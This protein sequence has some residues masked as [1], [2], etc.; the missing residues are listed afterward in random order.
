MQDDQNRL[1]YPSTPPPPR[2]HFALTP[3]R[4]LYRR[5]SSPSTIRRQS[6]ESNSTVGH[7][8]PPLV[9]LVRDMQEKGDPSLFMVSPRTTLGMT[10]SEY[11]C[12]TVESQEGD[13]VEARV[14]T[15]NQ[16]S[17]NSS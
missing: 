13:S 16:L 12:S 5:F 3:G 10:A 4:N 8:T 1:L 2:T 6:V 11:A 14:Y 7:G 9:R 15:G 17:T